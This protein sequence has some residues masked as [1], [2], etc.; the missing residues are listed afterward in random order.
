MLGWWWRCLGSGVKKAAYSP[1][2]APTGAGNPWCLLV[3]TMGNMS[4]LRTNF[5]LRSYKI[6]KCELGVNST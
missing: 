3:A 4:P 2:L 1:S 5:I 6:H